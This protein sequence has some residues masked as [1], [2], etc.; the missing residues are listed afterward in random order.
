MIKVA[1]V[2]HELWYTVEKVTEAIHSFK[3]EEL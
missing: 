2:T 1:L 3:I